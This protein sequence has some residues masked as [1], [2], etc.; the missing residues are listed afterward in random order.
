MGHMPQKM[1][2]SMT[3]KGQK[4]ASRMQKMQKNQQADQ[5][6][7]DE[8]DLMDEE[9]LAGA[10]GSSYESMNTFMKAKT[11]KDLKEKIEQN[12]Q[13]KESRKTNPIH[14]ASKLSQLAAQTANNE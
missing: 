9:L 6:A 5:P 8:K 7:V 11:Y 12:K 14:T 10:P 3:P 2:Y 13:A 1:N 4:H